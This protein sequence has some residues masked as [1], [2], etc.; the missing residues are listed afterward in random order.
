MRLIQALWV[1]LSM[2]S[3]IPVPRTEWNEEN[4]KYAICFFPVVG[5]VTGGIVYL[6]GECLLRFTSSNPL[7]LGVTLTLLP[8]LINGGIHLDGL[9]DTA[10]ARSSWGDREKKLAVLKDSHVGAFAV[11][12]VCCYFLWSAA[13]CSEITEEILPAVSLVYV[14]SRALSGLSVVTFPAAKEEGI[15]KTF[16][17][18]AQKRTVRVVMA[19]WIAAAFSG[20]VWL[21]GSLALPAAA[22]AAAAFAYYYRMSRREFGGIT[23]DLAGFFLCVCELLAVTGIVIA[24]GGLW[25]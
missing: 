12:S 9:M 25:N 22:C 10:D 21:G 20:M 18:K 6:A 19:L 11:L 5:A 1:A 7:F 15:L 4:M 13:V 17:G 23:G 3:K 24:G 14:L 2:Y 16:Q 8:V